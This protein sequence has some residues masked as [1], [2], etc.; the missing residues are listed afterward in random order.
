MVVS[1]VCLLGLSGCSS[2]KPV[3]AWE[4]GILAEPV[5][6]PAGLALHNGVNE[7]VF[8]SKEAV[9]GGGGVAGGGCGCN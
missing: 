7:H 8:T 9:R 2:I 5:M 6:S 1:F 3:K 4:K